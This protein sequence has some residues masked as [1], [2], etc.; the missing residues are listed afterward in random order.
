MKK[1]KIILL[2]ALLVCSLCMLTA[3][4]NNDTNRAADETDT[5]IEEDMTTDEL[6]PDGEE[7]VPYDD[8]RNQ[9]GVADE[10]TDPADRTGDENAEG[11]R[12]KNSTEDGL[13][14]DQE[15]HTG[16][17]DM[18]QK[19]D[20]AEND[21]N[22][23]DGNTKN[24]DGMNDSDSNTDTDGNNS[25]ENN[26]NANNTDGNNSNARTGSQENDTVSGELGN[27]VRDLGD[28]IG[29]VVE[30]TGDAIGNAAEGR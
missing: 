25:D 23:D 29:N 17:S 15:D 16:D 12:G 24:S 28:G 4:G 5:G 26:S 14:D 27:A 7:V 19:K 18:N 21:S 22:A 2:G 6:V 30:D 9:D 10:Q 13:L 20:N 11:G 8:D 1:K 3:C